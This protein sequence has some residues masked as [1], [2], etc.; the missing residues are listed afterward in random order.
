MFAYSQ[1]A[2]NGNVCRNANMI[3][4]NGKK[5][6]NNFLSTFLWYCATAVA[7]DDDEAF[8]VIYISY[9]AGFLKRNGLFSLIS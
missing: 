2:I 3:F 7:S 6:R 1:Q 9:Y 8:V 4:Q 5:T